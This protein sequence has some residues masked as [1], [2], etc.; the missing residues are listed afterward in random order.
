MIGALRRDASEPGI[1]EAL[2]AVGGS[3]Q[4]ISASGVPDLLVGW[5]GQMWLIECKLPLTARGALPS[6]RSLKHKG[7]VGDMT[8]VQVA[9]W[10][11]WQGPPPVVA[12]TPWDALLAIGAQNEPAA[13]R[14]R[15]L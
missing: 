12:R 9:W 1:V 8:A 7:G 11:T 15:P 14:Y 4:R 10:T 13:Q 2:L 3:A 5:R 6:G